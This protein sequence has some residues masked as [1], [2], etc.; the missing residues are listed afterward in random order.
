MHEKI[1]NIMIGGTLLLEQRTN[2][3]DFAQD[4]GRLIR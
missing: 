3:D 4:E 2:S 1:K